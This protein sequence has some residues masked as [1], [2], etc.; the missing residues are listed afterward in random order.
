MGFSETHNPVRFTSVLALQELKSMSSDPAA[1]DTNIRAVRA[2][3]D[4]SHTQHA[5][6][7]K[8]TRTGQ[9]SSR[10]V[11]GEEKQLR[12]SGEAEEQ[13]EQESGAKNTGEAEEKGKESRTR[14]E[15]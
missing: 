15:S 3:Q 1:I 12:S 14:R 7:R 13:G 9:F 5:H 10:R 6:T 2:Q 11:G 4:P 8:R